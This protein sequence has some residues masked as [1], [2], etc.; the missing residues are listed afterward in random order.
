MFDISASPLTTLTYKAVVGIWS[1]S[2]H[3]HVFYLCCGHKRH[4]MFQEEMKMIFSV[5]YICWDPG[6]QFRGQRHPSSCVCSIPTGSPF[7]N[8]SFL[9]NGLSHTTQDFLTFHHILS[10]VSPNLFIVTHF[11][12][13]LLLFSR[14]NSFS[15]FLPHSLFCGQILLHCS[16]SSS[17]VHCCLSCLRSLTLRCIKNPK[18]SLSFQPHTVFPWK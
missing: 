15:I 14:F 1:V 3:F 13:S 16:S 2:R 17:I 18:Q 11:L 5:L 6:L 10:S 8:L 4:K 7:L 9:S 12:H